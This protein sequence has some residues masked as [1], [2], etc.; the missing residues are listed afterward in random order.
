MKS[1]T[2]KGR[3]LRSSL[4]AG[5]AISMTSVAMPAFAQDDDEIEEIF[6]TGSRIARSDFTSESAI[7]VVTGED[8]ATSGFT[9]IAEALRQ[10]VGVT[11][12]GFS[13]SSVLSGGGATS[14]DLR[15]L[16]GDRV[17]TL[18]NGR[19]VAAFADSLQNE[20]RDLSF[21]PVAMVER[22]E[23]LRDGASATYGADAVTG[24][25]N[26]ILKD[27]FEGLRLSALQ[28]VAT[29]NWDGE[30][31]QLSAVMGGNFDRGNIVIG[32]EYRTNDEIYQRDRDWAFPSISSLGAGFNNGSFFSPG[33]LFWPDNSAAAE[34]YCTEPKAF[35]G[36]EI[37]NVYATAESCPSFRGGNDRKEL[38]RYDYALG[39]TL[40]N[41]H[42]VFNGSLYGRY[43][44]TDRTE[45]FVEMQVSKRESITRLDGNPGILRVPGTNPYLLGASDGTFYVRPASTV[46]PRTTEVDTNMMRAVAGFNGDFDFSMPG[47]LETNFTWEVSYLWTKVDTQLETDGIYNPVRMEMMAD[48]AACAANALCTQALVD[49]G[50]IPGVDALDIIRPGNWL[51]QEIQFFEQGAFSISEFETSGVQAFIAGDLWELPA[52]PIGMAIG[53][54]YREDSGRAKP[55]SVTESGES[56]ANRVF[57]TRGKFDTSE[58]FA[59]FQI[60]VFKDVCLLDD[61]CVLQDLSLN[62]QG[63]YFDFSNFGSDTVYKIG[64]N[65]V[66]SDDIRLRGSRGTSF[67][68]PTIV[69][70]FNG[71]TDSFDFVND[72]CNDYQLLNPLLDNN[73]NIQA[74][75]AA[76]G[77][78]P[79]FTQIASQYRV[80]RGGNPNLSPET[81]ESWA[82]GVVLTPSMVPNLAISIDYWQLE[83]ENPI[84]LPDSSDA[85][86]N[87]CYEGAQLLAD[88]FCARFSRS[89]FDGS[90][91]G[92]VNKLGNDDDRWETSGIDWGINY[93]YDIWDGVLSLSNV[94]SWLLDFNLSPG[95]GGAD[96]RGSAPEVKTTASATFERDNWGATWSVRYIGDMD[97][98]DFDGNNAF[99]Y[100][101]PEQQIEHDARFNYAWDKYALTLGVNNVFDEEPPYIFASGN[102]T[103]VFTYG[104]AVV[105]RYI[106]ARLVADF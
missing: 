43:E 24:V 106:F 27:D 83:L 101:G 49:A 76:D 41:Q 98:P 88:P 52:G 75:C 21:I 47:F 79:G 33:G 104:S 103:D 64:L 102:N 45:F 14:V 40:L 85:I 50:K 58:A 55:D 39:Q 3:L 97:D 48:P 31:T 87:Q 89:P 34:F 28:G 26:I 60:P 53:Y 72:P 86:I 20:A 105:G 77:I 8:L 80:L 35:G 44:V 57:S 6:V 69:D 25:I 42:H 73:A 17:L 61:L 16:G 37:T 10:Q 65:W 46:G 91:I 4:L 19:R 92:L 63:R 70:L 84:G 82:G 66:V 11:S 99:N 2:L 38:A 95:V 18:I 100:D 22:V 15:N 68:A 32:M 62:L 13:Q 30:Q 1:E 96:D 67:R 93:T 5:V 59:E 74:N 81:S 12:G 78:A 90:V 7:T 29:N 36:D 94:G 71:G 56:I 9:T 51:P 23:I 54:E